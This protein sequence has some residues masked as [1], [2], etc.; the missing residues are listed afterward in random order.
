[1]YVKIFMYK[2]NV[3]YRLEMHFES[4]LRPSAGTRL[5]CLHCEASWL[6]GWGPISFCLFLSTT[7]QVF[8]DGYLS[9]VTIIAREYPSHS[10]R[11]CSHGNR[12]MNRQLTRKSLIQFLNST[13]CSGIP[14]RT[15][16]TTP[17]QMLS[18]LRS[19]SHSS[20]LLR[21]SPLF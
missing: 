17:Y 14:C 16:T 15:T 13:A 18:L 11:A 1:V 12:F 20:F 2:G 19:L 5:L 21:S 3:E 4:D 8:L 7:F 6:K 10:P 9:C